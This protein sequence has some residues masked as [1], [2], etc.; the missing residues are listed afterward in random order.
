LFGIF[1]EITTWLWKFWGKGW[2]FAGRSE[3]FPLRSIVK[4]MKFAWISQEFYCYLD[5]V[6]KIILLRSNLGLRWIVF[7][8]LR[9]ENNFA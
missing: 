2:G 8:R 9:G 1:G 7:F 6:A 5:R 3:N 4:R